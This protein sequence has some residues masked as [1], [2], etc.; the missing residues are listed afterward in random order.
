MPQGTVKPAN[1]IVI[2]GVSITQEME[3]GA[4]ATAA[5]M[6][7]GRFVI[8]DGVNDTVKEAGAKAHGVVGLLDVASDK[9][10]ANN[11]AVGDQARVIRGPSGLQV[12]VTL[13][14]SE[15]VTRGDRLVTAANG[16]VAKQAVGAMGAQGSVV[17][18]ADESSNVTV[19][20]EIAATL[21][22][23]EEPAAAS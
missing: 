8:Y 7:P 2:N 18:I 3:V 23:T 17:A 11:Y 6:V 16:K 13:L 21:T 1:S 15:N 9:L 22:R 14:A 5:Q 19:D 4:A 10:E 20:A 12:K